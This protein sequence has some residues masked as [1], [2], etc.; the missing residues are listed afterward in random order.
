MT[1][2]YFLNT[3]LIPGLRILQ[4]VGGPDATVFDARRFLLCI[5]MQES[6][7]SLDA[8][9]Q[10]S[11]SVSPGPARG[12]WQFESSGGVKGVLTHP[13]SS[14]LAKV[15]CGQCHVQPQQDAVWRAIEGHDTLATGFARLLVLTSPH[16]L[17]KTQQE[18]WQQYANE[19]WRPGKPNPDVWPNN[20][21][22]AT[23]TVSN[24]ANA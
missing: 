3:V 23:S 6:G 5:A 14:D 11:P 22:T 15:L 8:R 13:A 19:L 4:Q 24:N 21:Q 7:K 10:S 2:V 12:W 1:P 20:W 17:P 9:Y 18:G 16:A